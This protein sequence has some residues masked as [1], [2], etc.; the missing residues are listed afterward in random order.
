MM[1]NYWGKLFTDWR[2]AKMVVLEWDKERRGIIESDETW[3]LIIL[4]MF[5]IDNSVAHSEK[6]KISMLMKF[7][8]GAMYLPLISLRNSELA[9]YIVATKDKI[10]YYKNNPEEE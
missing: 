6:E 8:G 10:N 9:K 3:D 5:N 7:V 4:T 2:E 1:K